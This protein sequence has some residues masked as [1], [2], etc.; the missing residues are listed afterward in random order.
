MPPEIEL[1]HSVTG[2]MPT[3]RISKG[4]LG[5]VGNGF[6]KS[7]GKAAPETI[8]YLQ[9]KV[10]MLSFYTYVSLIALLRPLNICNK[11]LCWADVEVHLK[12]YRNIFS[13][14]N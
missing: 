8:T 13:N 2:R 3:H 10:G 11:C 5:T 6:S 4:W 7:D 12:F 9:L 1:D 14:K